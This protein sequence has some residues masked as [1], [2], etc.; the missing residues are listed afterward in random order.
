MALFCD[1]RC[2]VLDAL[3]SDILLSNHISILANISAYE[4]QRNRCSGS[5]F[6]LRAAHQLSLSFFF[7]FFFFFGMHFVITPVCA[8][9]NFVK[10]L[11]A[12]FFVYS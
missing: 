1:V 7:F 8:L 11:S 5:S 4:T 12:D 9:F 6:I 10:L 2:A 3:I